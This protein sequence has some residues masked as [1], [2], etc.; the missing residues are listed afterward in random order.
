MTVCDRQPQI[1]NDDPHF[2]VPSKCKGSWHAFIRLNALR[3]RKKERQKRINI[4]D[5]IF[6]VHYAKRKLCRDT[7]THTAYGPRGSGIITK[8]F[9]SQ[10]PAGESFLFSM[11]IARYCMILLQIPSIIETF[12]VPLLYLHVINATVQCDCMQ[13]IALANPAI[14]WLAFGYF[15][16]HT[17]T[18]LSALGVTREERNKYR[19]ADNTTLSSNVTFITF[20]RFLQTAQSFLKNHVENTHIR[21]QLHSPAEE[22]LQN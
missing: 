11:E 15:V 8:C 9:H 14:S 5:E 19:D 3:K 1:L 13:R 7:A 6:V 2:R 21:R 17:P 4:L 22:W 18:K 16:L 10:P 12:S 20:K